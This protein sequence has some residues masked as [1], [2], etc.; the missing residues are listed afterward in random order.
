MITSNIIFLWSFVSF[1]FSQRLVRPP[2]QDAHPE[3]PSSLLTSGAAKEED[4]VHAH[5]FCIKDFFCSS[6]NK[7]STTDCGNS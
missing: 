6:G 5:S 2:P 1:F 7:I 4:A 3:D